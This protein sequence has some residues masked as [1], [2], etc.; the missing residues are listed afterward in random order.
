MKEKL[1]KIKGNDNTET[2][3]V[4]GKEEE[5]DGRK[6]QVRNKVTHPKRS[7]NTC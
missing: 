1:W 6:S 2:H 5:R 7:R 4:R 3:I